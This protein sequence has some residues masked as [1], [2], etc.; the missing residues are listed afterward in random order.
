M[1]GFGESTAIYFEGV[2]RINH[3][4]VSRPIVPAEDMMQAFAYWHLVPAQELRLTILNAKRRIIPA[5][6]TSTEKVLLSA[7]GTIQVAYR[8]PPRVGLTDIKLQLDEPPNGITLK[9]VVNERGSLTLLL[10]ADSK[11]VKPGLRDNLIIEAFSEV[12]RKDGKN[13][14]TKQRVSLGILPAIPIQIIK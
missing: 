12:E 11:L 4:L 7:G 6:L 9:D 10:A 3:Q 13:T 5:E 14:G 8:V 2:A 1:Q